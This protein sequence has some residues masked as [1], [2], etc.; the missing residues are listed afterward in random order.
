MVL[1]TGKVSENFGSCW[2]LW[3]IL[4]LCAW[5]AF[6]DFNNVT[7]QSKKSGGRIYASSSSRGLAKVLEDN[8]G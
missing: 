3:L 5:V 7:G 1:L 4:L 8:L 2:V 6:G